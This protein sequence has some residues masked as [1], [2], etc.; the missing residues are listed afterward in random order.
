MITPPGHEPGGFDFVTDKNK[1]VTHER[2]KNAVLLVPALG[3]ERRC[4]SR[5]STQQRA[6]T[7][8]NLA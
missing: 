8:S 1:Q 5:D 4:L 3:F 2:W 6:F 7:S